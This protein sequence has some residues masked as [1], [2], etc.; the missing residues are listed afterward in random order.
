VAWDAPWNKPNWMTT[1]F[2]L[3]Y[4]WHSLIPDTI[5]WKNTPYPVGQTILNNAPLLGIGLVD[6]FH[7]MSAQPAAQLGAFN[8]ADSLLGFE[9]RAI[10]QGRECHVATYSDYRAYAGLSRPKTFADVS[11][12][13][14][15][16][17]LL[18]SAYG[19]PANI[20]FYVGLFAEDLVEHSPLPPLILAMVA[21]D[22]F[23]QALT[24]PLL[25]RHVFNEATFSDVGWEAIGNTSSLKDVLARNSPPGALGGKRISMTR[26]GWSR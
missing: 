9:E 3:L 6:A 18:R 16:V 15:V 10:A 12:D 1:E 2:S 13:P 21:V 23:S 24:N 7:E 14:R 5:A 4:R 19:T 17:H 11:S 25:S 22:A 8:T 20:E 26:E